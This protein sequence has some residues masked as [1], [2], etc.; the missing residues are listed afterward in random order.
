MVRGKKILLGVCGGI[1]AYKAAFLIRLLIKEGAEVQV[2]MTPDARAFITPLT[3]STLSG[4]PV[5]VDY[6]DPG[7][8]EWNNHVELALWAD[9]ILVVPATAHTLAKFAHGICDNLLVAV[10]LSAKSPVLLAPAMDLDMWKH[11]ST[12]ANIEVLQSFGNRIIPPGTGELASG[13]V[14]EGRLA[15]PEDIV[16]FITSFLEERAEAM[17]QDA[18]TASL[19]GKKVLVTAGPTYEAIDPVRFIGNHSTGKM[20][21][22]IAEELLRKGA[23]V[24]LVHGPVQVPLPAAQAGLHLHSVMS[25]SDM[26]A[27]CLGLSTEA[28]AVVMAAAVADYTPVTPAKMKIKKSDENLSIPLQRTTDI[29]STLGS[30]KRPGQILVGFALETDNEI[31]NAQS[32]L[33]RKNLDF[34]VLNSM[35]DDGAGFGG[36]TNKVTIFDRTGGHT[37]VDLKDKREV[38]ADIV[39]LTLAS[40]MH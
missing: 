7:T 36:D 37:L 14:G 6:Y 23:E 3:L 19:A 2:V 11:G 16:R 15:E 32:K 1:A 8:G 4:R 25:A 20:G 26:A 10:Y 9:L 13:L 21:I 17:S 33:K 38:A 39:R 5:L 12:L 18:G 30:G 29:L 27:V 31:A 28:D 40:L 22:A 24:F 35:R 34:I